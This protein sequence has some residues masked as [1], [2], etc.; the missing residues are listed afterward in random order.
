[1]K[2]L[3]VA[4]HFVDPCVQAYLARDEAQAQIASSLAEK[5]TLRAQLV[6]L[7]EEIFTL[8]AQTTQTDPSQTSVSDTRLHSFTY[9]CSLTLLCSC[10]GLFI[11]GLFMQQ[12]S[13]SWDSSQD[14]S[15]DSPPSSSM[16][17]PRLRRMNALLP[18]CS[19]NGEN[20]KVGSN[21]NKHF[22]NHHHC[23]L[24]LQQ[25]GVQEHMKGISYVCVPSVW[26]I[27]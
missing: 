11:N 2:V 21:F 5:D 6:D 22:T 9:S 23:T 12:R 20:N 10:I 13:L 15:C 19:N 4:L 17:R 18:G 27:L 26:I 25:S 3:R 1:M 7:Q 24:S 8:R 16:R 14:M